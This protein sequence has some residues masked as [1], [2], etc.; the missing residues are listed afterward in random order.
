MSVVTSIIDALRKF[1]SATQRSAI[2]RQDEQLQGR[3][4]AERRRDIAR[5]ELGQ[6]EVII[7]TTAPEVE[8]V[9]S[10]EE[11]ELEQIAKNASLVNAFAE[12]FLGHGLRD[13]FLEDLDRAFSIWSEASD[14]RG[15]QSE[16]VIE[17]AGAAFGMFCVDTLNMQ[18]VRITDQYGDALALQGSLKDFRGYPYHSI[19]KRIEMGE[20]GFFKSIY[21]SLQDVSQG[22]LKLTN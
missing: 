18:W 8:T 17:I 4:V 14:R 16:E 5:S 10:L 22:D 13:N 1:G 12:I 7:A 20:H 11:S 3:T 9:T 19:S 6:A 15:Y 21:I 2:R